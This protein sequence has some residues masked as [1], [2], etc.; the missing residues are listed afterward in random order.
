MSNTHWFD[1]LVDTWASFISL[2]LIS[3]PTISSPF[4]ED[5][6]IFDLKK[7]PTFFESSPVFFES[8]PVCNDGFDSEL[9]SKNFGF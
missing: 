5:F 8:S 2:L 3:T 9:F 6:P 1:L 7:S 4:T